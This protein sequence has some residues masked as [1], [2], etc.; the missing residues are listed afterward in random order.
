MV[1]KLGCRLNYINEVLC[2]DSREPYLPFC[3]NVRH[4]PDGPN[5]L[6][7]MIFTAL[8]GGALQ[9]HLLYHLIEEA[10]NHIEPWSMLW[11]EYETQTAYK[12]F[13]DITLSLLNYELWAY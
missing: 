6:D 13:K 10:F 3:S 2:H 8:G 5:P 9:E 12:P 11:C 7:K 1:E 4:Y